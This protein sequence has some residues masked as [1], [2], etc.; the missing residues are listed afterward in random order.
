[1]CKMDSL[2]SKITTMQGN[3]KNAVVEEIINALRKS[4][5]E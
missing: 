4:S 3:V 5:L 1:M 2:P